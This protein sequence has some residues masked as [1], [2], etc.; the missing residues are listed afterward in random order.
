MSWPPFWLRTA[1][2]IH[3]PPLSWVEVTSICEILV[4]AVALAD[5]DVARQRARRS[6]A[7][8]CDTIDKPPSL[9]AA[10]P[11]PR[12]PSARLK[13]SAPGGDVVWLVHVTA[14]L[15]TFADAT[16]PDAPDVVHV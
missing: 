8:A 9:I 15:V 1:G 7:T 11:A 13:S 5:P 4:A 3:S 2:P 12:P 10:Q 16:V 14:T 6:R